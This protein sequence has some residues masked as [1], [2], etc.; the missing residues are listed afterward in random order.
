MSVTSLG[1]IFATET[2]AGLKLTS[3][4]KV[5]ARSQMQVATFRGRRNQDQRACISSKFALRKTWWAQMNARM[6]ELNE[7]SDE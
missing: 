7:C 2:M 4:V 5:K 1:K 3:K 6:N